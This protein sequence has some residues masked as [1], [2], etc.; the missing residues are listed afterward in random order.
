LKERRW[1]WEK[2][3]GLD[4]KENIKVVALAAMPINQNKGYLTIEYS[5]INKDT[6]DKEISDLEDN[7]F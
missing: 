7:A 4:L 1:F 6:C 5:F 3:K 2:E